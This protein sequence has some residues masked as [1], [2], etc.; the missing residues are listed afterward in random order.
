MSSS[1]HEVYVFLIL[2]NDFW[3]DV[4]NEWFQVTVHLSEHGE[5][6]IITLFLLGL[7]ADFCDNAVH[8]CFPLTNS[9]DVRL[10]L[11]H[12]RLFVLVALP[13]H[14]AEVGLADVLGLRALHS[15]LDAADEGI[16]TGMITS[17]TSLL[18]SFFDLTSREKL[19]LL[20]DLVGTILQFLAQGARMRLW[21][22]RLVDA[23]WAH[24]LISHV[25][26]HPVDVEGARLGSINWWI[27]LNFNHFVCVYCFDLFV[28]SD[29]F[30]F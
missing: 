14:L 13:G 19:S 17:Q 20:E 6:V 27:V 25:I 9:L 22:P 10:V 4:S 30:D 18:N 1:R 16:L 23:V 3:I 11:V 26:L 12:L 28:F 7:L 21:E 2:L 8:G 29:A 5:T 15:R 24:V